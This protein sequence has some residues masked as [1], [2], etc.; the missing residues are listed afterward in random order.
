MANQKQSDYYFTNLPLSLHNFI[1]PEKGAIAT[2]LYYLSLGNR[3]KESSDIETAESKETLKT[4]RFKLSPIGESALNHLIEAGHSKSS[5]IIAAIH[6]LKSKPLTI[7]K[8]HL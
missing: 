1:S 2:G 4:L 5:A 8:T 6:Y 3:E 7:L